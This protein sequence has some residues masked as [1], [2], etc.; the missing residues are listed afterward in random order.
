VR[1]GESPAQRRANL[2]L[3]RLDGVD[4]SAESLLTG[5]AGGQTNEFAQEVGF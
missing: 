1:H 4:Y 2:R 3:A 5:V